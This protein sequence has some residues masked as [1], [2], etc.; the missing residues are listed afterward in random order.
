MKVNIKYQPTK[1]KVQ[2]YR[3]HGQKTVEDLLGKINGEIKAINNNLRG[4]YE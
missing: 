1:S 2:V 3:F 4:L